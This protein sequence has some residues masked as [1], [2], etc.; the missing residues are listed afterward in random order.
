MGNS[1]LVS[2]AI[3]SVNYSEK[4]N[5]LTNFEPFILEIIKKTNP[6]H[7]SR[8]DLQS[9]MKEEFGLEIPTSIIKIICRNLWN[10]GYL[11]SVKI[12]EFSDKYFYK[13][14]FE[15]IDSIDLISKS[16]EIVKKFDTLVISFREFIVNNFEEYDEIDLS[17][18]K[19]TEKI[20]FFIKENNVNLVLDTKF[21]DKHEKDYDNYLVAS[22]V[23]YIYEN[24]KKNYTTFLN[25]VKGNMLSEALYY[26][27]S[28]NFEKKFTGSKFYFDTSFIM[29]A[30]GYSGAERQ[31]PCKELLDLLKANEAELFCFERNI[32]EVIGILTWSKH[33]LNSGK[34]SHNTIS[35]FREKGIKE[36]DIDLIISDLENSIES[37]L[38][39]I[40]S[41]DIDYDHE[42]YSNVID[43]NGFLEFLSKN[44]S[45]N[46]D[47]S[48]DN[49][50]EAVGS[51]MR[52]RKRKQPTNI[53]DCGAIFVTT[54]NTLAKKTKEY[55]ISQ[56]N[57]GIPP[58][59]TDSVITN[60]VWL[61]NPQ[62]HP[63]LPSLKLVADCLAAVNP[64]DRLW[65]KY[66]DKL[67]LL[68]ASSEL[69]DKNKIVTLRYLPE[70]KKILMDKT[71]GDENAITEGTASEILKE[72]EKQRLAEIDLVK[73]KERQKAQIS[74]IEHKKEN[75]KLQ[76]ELD[77]REDANSNTIKMIRKRSDNKAVM[78]TWV[79][80]VLCGFLLGIFS[81]FSLE[82]VKLPS[83][84]Q[85]G[86]S[87]LVAVVF[88]VIGFILNFMEVDFIA[89]IK[90]YQNK[91]SE[92]FF[93]KEC[94]K[95]KINID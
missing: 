91:L 89:K 73:E 88:P 44:I 14:N 72:I 65:N 32:T 45:Y 21:S 61:K 83:N 12:H 34:D 86:I 43:Y 85:V 11:F 36:E 46:K 20:D 10:K 23:Q 76:N 59:L 66:I 4:N 33:H 64:S 41:P 84:Y 31:L 8:E 56:K 52:L 74:I 35:Y 53:E 25:I 60:L 27:S 7:I 92:Q 30:M 69:I 70:A 37:Q 94:K 78:I 67:E 6:E 39:I 82:L 68:I 42:D 22:F 71:M 17:N 50:V 75:E 47:V 9:G 40:V 58:V 49:D 48:L 90:T 19:L 5:F 51:I 29:Y 95:L 79:M 24:D 3:L 13:P 16:D 2:Y 38:G 63:N 26:N 57:I 80:V 1:E 15:K 28:G 54:N 55:F 87:I 18:E 81:F 93:Q 62:L 77:K